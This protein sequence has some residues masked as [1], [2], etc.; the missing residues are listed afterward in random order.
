MEEVINEDNELAGHLI[1]KSE[2]NF[3]NGENEE[4]EGNLI[5]KSDANQENEPNSVNGEN[6]EL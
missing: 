6:D 2:A 3:N 4:L 5:V 1:V